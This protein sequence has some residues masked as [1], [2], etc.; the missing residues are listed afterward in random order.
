MRKGDLTR[1]E[2]TLHTRMRLVDW[3]RTREAHALVLLAAFASCVYIVYER[4]TRNVVC[5]P[6]T[7]ASS[8]EAEDWHGISS[9]RQTSEAFQE[10]VP[11]C[12]IVSNWS[13]I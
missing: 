9:R 10:R 6:L 4:R 3:L 13:S 11:R 5:S 7:S 1:W 2:D 8:N 12:S